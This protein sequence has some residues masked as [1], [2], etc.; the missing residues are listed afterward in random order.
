MSMAL[1]GCEGPEFTRVSKV[2]GC[3]S[4]FLICGSVKHS[5]WR[6]GQKYTR[7]YRT[8]RLGSGMVASLLSE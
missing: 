3:E 6:S 2:H 1:T 8:Y 7:F 4:L 5:R